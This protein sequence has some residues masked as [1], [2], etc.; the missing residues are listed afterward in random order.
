MGTVFVS[1]SH[2]DEKW[3]DWLEPHLKALENLGYVTDF[4]DDR[5]IDAGEEW[6]PEIRAAMEKADIAVCL[7]SPNFLA[8]DFC[9][10]E[11]VTYFLEQRK[12]EKMLIIPIL[13]RPCLWK[14]HKWLSGTQMLPRDGKCMAV[15]Y[16]SNY[17]TV[18]LE[19]TN[20]IMMGGGTGGFGSPPEQG[21]GKAAEHGL[22]DTSTA[23]DSLGFK[24]YVE[25]VAGFLTHENTMPPLVLSVEG[26]WGSGKSSFMWQ[27]ENEIGQTYK[28]KWIRRIADL[29]RV[30]REKIP[31]LMAKSIGLTAKKPQIVK[32]DPWRH[33]KDDALWA[34]FALKFLDQARGRFYRLRRWLGDFLLF[35]KR[36][37]WA[38]GWIDFAKFFGVWAIFI[39]VCIV[40]GV[41]VHQRG[42]DWA[43]DLC[44]GILETV[45]V[46]GGATAKDASI[47]GKF[48]WI[49]NTGGWTALLAGV[50]SLFGQVK[51]VT[52]NPLKTNLKKYIKHPNYAGR[53]SFIDRFH[54]D[55]KKIVTAYAGKN[56]IYV[57]IDDLDR[58]AVPKAAELMESINLMISDNPNLVFIMGMDREKVA[59]GLA[60]KHEKLLPYLSGKMDQVEGKEIDDKD[61]DKDKEKRL[62]G[63]LYGYSFLEKFIQIPFYLPHPNEDAIKKL[64]LS[65]PGQAKEGKVYPRANSGDK[66]SGDDSDSK[67]LNQTVEKLPDEERHIEKIEGDN[68]KFREMAMMVAPALGNN[69]RRVKQ[70][71]NLLRLRFRIA[72]KTG[73]L[74]IDG[75]RG[76][77]TFEQL[78]KFVGIG[79]R[80]PLLMGEIQRKPCLLNDLSKNSERNEKVEIDSRYER[81]A[82]ESSK[83]TE[84]LKAGEGEDY[85]LTNVNIERLLEV[86]PAVIRSVKEFVEK[87]VEPER[88]EKIDIDRLPVTGAQLFGRKD[89]IGLLDEAWDENTKNVLS[90]VAWGGGGKSTLI[91]KWLEYMGDDNY[92][93]ARWVYGWSFYSQ[94]TSERVT[95]ADAFVAHALEWFGDEDMA[96]NAK[97]AW[98]K[99]QRLAEL[100]AKEKTLLILDGLEPLQSGLDFEK[101]KIKDSALEVMLRGLAKKNPG[102]CVITTR[103]EVPELKRYAET[104]QSVGL[105]MISKEAGRALLRVEGVRGTDAELEGVV[106]AF[107]C[108]AL[109]VNLLGVYL[110]GIEGHEIEH[111]AKIPDLPE[112]GVDDGKHP[113]RVIEAIT[114]GFGDGAELDVLRILGMFDRPAEMEA[115]E[116]V[117]GDGA[118]EG[119]TERLHEM[120]PL[121]REKIFERLRKHKL[122]AEEHRH[123]RGVL[124]CHPLVREHFGEKLKAE[125]I[126]AWRAGHDRL[127]E[128][129]KGLPEKLYGK[130]LPDTLEEM[131]PLF[132]AVYHG[133]QAQKVQET[134]DDV[135]WDRISRG[136]EYSV[137]QLGAFGS[138]L[139]AA[140]CFF[141]KLW[142]EPA[143]GLSKS[144]KA[145]VLNLAGYALRA[146]GRLNEAAEP[147]TV[148]VEMRNKQENWLDASVDA[149]NVSEL[150]LTLGQVGKAMEFAKRAVEYADKSGDEFQ[151][152]S[153]RTSYGDALCQGG[154][155]KRAKE[156]F[157]EA[158][159]MQAEW[160][161]EYPLLYSWGGH[162]YCDLL[163]GEGEYEK[164]LERARQTLEYGKSFYGLLS[165]ALDMLSIGRALMG[166]ANRGGGDWDEAGEW[167]DR[168]VNGLREAGTQ[169]QIPRG[170]LCRGAMYRER[171]MFDEAMRDLDEVYEIAERGGMKL[172]MV[173][174]NLEA[175]RVCRAM[176][177]GEGERRHYDAARL[178][179]EE[180][181][182]HRRDF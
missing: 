129:Y 102:L 58:C 103:L 51:K 75:G 66:G 86:S 125:N 178:G 41:A 177:D 182:Y 27:L 33:D 1:Y 147:M 164:V 76:E 123:N 64:L 104:A 105:E 151:R 93:G 31:V 8:S 52:G 172:F 141:D 13:I 81:W 7:I 156:L 50:V 169:H 54:E 65:L 74:R 166:L 20:R 138:D 128:Y 149:G 34:A 114:Q 69:P 121:E 57:F 32:F 71:V 83:L 19:V 132:R 150:Y 47:P 162:R 161:P 28:E 108:H 59:A 87:K 72:I 67:K 163:L 109:A 46:E 95:S 133:C 80:W 11:E 22:S 56:R 122:L 101:G 29:L 180:T 155:V 100:I 10:K 43:T 38:D 107:G 120:K 26:E 136:N 18:F 160:Q 62:R 145:L 49:V 110:H 168:A 113:R 68:E 165:K 126:D 63:I 90:F 137:H 134:L 106:E 112:V 96:K 139:G 39:V 159:R 171:G 143:E 152:M 6:Y 79:L 173:D 158:E 55:F 21:I 5:D 61:E 2:K 119:L 35:W 94:G 25:A 142:S 30:K 53:I 9:M 170:L 77:I 60:V 44:E 124:D 130:E 111:A 135:Y 82:N 176:G 89:E 181:G 167:L 148:A 179:V 146:V 118:I 97:S 175:G 91:N 16:K 85:S 174:Y 12:E 92:R 37:S 14:E 42:L 17:D 45:Q 157:E 73:L 154:D 70:F 115:F 24:P 40:L 78:G 144:D 48:K 99:G 36:F 117:C 84:L 131:E 127:Y 4:W 3:K 98:D 15:D 140:A 116:A 23:E 153:K 88:P